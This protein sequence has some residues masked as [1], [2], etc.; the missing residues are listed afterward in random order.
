M[1]NVAARNLVKNGH[2]K[3]V[4]CFQYCLTRSVKAYKLQV[5]LL[6]SKRVLIADPSIQYCDSG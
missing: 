6:I 4:L 1:Y 3:H 5:D 2:I